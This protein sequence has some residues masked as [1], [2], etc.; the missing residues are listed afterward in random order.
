MEAGLSLP[1]WRSPWC[2]AIAGIAGEAQRQAADVGWLAALQAQ[3]RARALPVGFV[4]HDR[5]PAGVAYERHVFEH[6]L[7]PTRLEAHDILNAL[8]WLAFPR[9]KRCINRM[10]AQAIE[11]LGVGARRG[12]LRD[13]L[14]LF[15]ENG[16]VLHAPPP[17][18]Q[19]L[20][21]REWKR[22][23]GELRPLWRQAR[24]TIFG[25]ALLEQ[26]GAAPRKPL[27]AHVLHVDAPADPADL[28]GWLAE[29]LAD[30]GWI[31]RKP[32]APLPVL[33]V[34]LWWAANE[35]PA[36]YDDASVFRPARAARGRA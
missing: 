26:L 20:A 33:G 31:E 32:F 4:A 9:A 23:F 6:K 35:A 13:A 12:P 21:A 25:H 16:A 11:R 22:L 1:D 17:L 36:F 2:A 10:Q 24:L 29:A 34:P 5:L 19:A 3:A 30:A 8:V 14:T 18:W 27:T 7:V 28:D 15:D